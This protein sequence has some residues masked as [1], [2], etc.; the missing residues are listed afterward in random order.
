MELNL[1][2]SDLGSIAVLHCSGRILAG[3]SADSLL[4]E[5]EGLLCQYERLVIDLSTVESIDAGG[6][7]ALVR[8]RVWASI[9]GQEIV[10]LNPFKMTALLELV[11]IHELFEVRYCRQGWTA[12]FNADSASAAECA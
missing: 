5:A 1:T 6:L 11:G 12:H 7:G 4:R 8:I 10:L 3:P 9:G 2:T